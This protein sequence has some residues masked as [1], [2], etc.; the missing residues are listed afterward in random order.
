MERIRQFKTDT[1]VSEYCGVN[2]KKYFY[3]YLWKKNNF[4]WT[5]NL[6]FLDPQN[7]LHIMRT[8]LYYISM[9]LWMNKTSLENLWQQK[10]QLSGGFSD[11]LSGADRIRCG[12]SGTPSTNNI[13]LHDEEV[14]VTDLGV[15]LLC[16]E[17]RQFIFFSSVYTVLINVI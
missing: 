5:V 6:Y 14:G 7:Y 16:T 8:F 10:I 12:V 1:G 13:Y 17:S 15:I 11:Y 9:K 4:L 3:E 2:G